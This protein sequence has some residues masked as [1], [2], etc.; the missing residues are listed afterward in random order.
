MQDR[1][2]LTPI[3]PAAALSDAEMAALAWLARYDGH[4]LRAYQLDLREW[5]SWSSSQGLDPLHGV[6]RPHIELYGRWLDEHRHL[7][8][9]TIARRLASVAGYFRFAHLDGTIESNPAA[10]IRR[11]KVPQESQ[12]LGLDRMELAAFIGAGKAGTPDDCA[13]AMLLGVLG[14]RVSEACGIDITDLGVERGHRTLSLVGKGGKPAL[15]PLPPP[16]ARAVDAAAGPRTEGPLLR[17]STG[18]RMERSCATRTV[19][20]LARQAGISKA[21]SPHS[22]RHSAIT[23][24]LDAGVPLRDVQ[25]LARHSDPRTTMRY[26]RARHN[27]DRHASYIVAAYVAGAA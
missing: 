3:R 5:F 10:Y 7:A 12:R 16:V 2:V 15:M 19:K 8:P 6:R 20:R 26:D 9:G 4:T 24:A 25:E 21:I 1:S 18:A 11:P 14:L 13:L 23:A 22:L 27:L 17:S